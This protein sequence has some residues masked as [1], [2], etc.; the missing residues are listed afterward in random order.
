MRWTMA[1]LK[2][3]PLPLE[4]LRPL[5]TPAIGPLPR[6]VRRSTAALFTDIEKFLCK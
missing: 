2:F 1:K 6:P 3:L 4:V 5:D